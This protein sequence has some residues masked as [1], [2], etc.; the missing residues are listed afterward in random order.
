MMFFWRALGLMLIGMA[1]M[2]LDVFAAARSTRFYGWMLLIG[3]GVGLPIV[4]FGAFEQIAHA[5][6][7]VYQMLAGAHYNYAGS[8]LVSLGYVGLVMLVVK[9]GAMRGLTSRL[10]AVGRMALTNY[11][12]QTLICTSIFFG[13]GLG[14]FARVERKWLPL[15]VVGVWLLQLLWSP[16]W[17]ARFRFGPAEWLWRSLTYGHRQPFSRSALSA[18]MS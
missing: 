6:D 4:I 5:F 18:G 1:L 10:G 12:A 2:K 8:V 3:L 7:P 15:C 16:W 9:G 17:L 14:Y 13:W 11:L